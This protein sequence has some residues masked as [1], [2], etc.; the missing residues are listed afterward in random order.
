MKRLVLATLLGLSILGSSVPARSFDMG[1]TLKT[2]S[3]ETSTFQTEALFDLEAVAKLNQGSFVKDGDRATLKFGARIVYLFKSSADIIVDGQNVRLESAVVIQS[4]RWA[5][6]SSLL[7]ALQLR[8][9]KALQ[10]ETFVDPFQLNWE[11]LELKTGAKGLHLFWRAEGSSLD[12]ASVFLMPFELTSKLDSKMNLQKVV[13][14]LNSKYPGRILYF[15]VA[16]D[17]G[18]FTPDQLEF[19]QGGTRYIV[20]QNAGLYSFEGQFPKASLGAIKLPSS[21]NLREPIRVIWGSNG[22]DYTFSK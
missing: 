9:P 7:E 21:F 22:A 15:S 14:V 17:A 2:P 20:E 10:T 1:R 8:A 13:G 5:A 16:A 6:P 19:V 18:G 11:E 12:E 3:F 4:K